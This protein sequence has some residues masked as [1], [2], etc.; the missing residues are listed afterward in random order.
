LKISS[1]NSNDLNSLPLIIFP[2]SLAMGV[3]NTKNNY[4]S[5]F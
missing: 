1:E 5:I 3:D 4:K 2:Q